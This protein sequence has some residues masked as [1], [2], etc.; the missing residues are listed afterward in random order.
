MSHVLQKRK[1]QTL[2]PDFHQHLSKIWLA[3]PDVVLE[4]CDIT[5]EPCGLPGW[6]QSDFS[7]NICHGEVAKARVLPVTGLTL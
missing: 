3:V 4:G 7:Y 6:C 2:L 5:L 1:W